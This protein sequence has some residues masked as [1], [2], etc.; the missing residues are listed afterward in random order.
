M[1]EWSLHINRKCSKLFLPRFEAGTTSR[2]SDDSEENE[3]S[4]EEE[5]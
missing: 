4:V 5:E 1:I 2:A 3:T